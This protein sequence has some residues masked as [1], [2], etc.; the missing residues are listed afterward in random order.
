MA[1]IHAASFD[2]SWDALEMSA[3][4]Q[5]DVCLGTG[6][7]LSAFIICSQVGDQ[8]E[9][10]TLATH[11][12][13]RQNGLGYDLLDHAIQTLRHT[14]VADL[15][16]EV[17]EDNVAAKALYRKMG[18]TPIGRRPGYYRRAKGRVA[19]ITFSKKL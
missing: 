19:A 3:H 16:L 6:D 17:A 12:D 11:P 14:G 4:C 8:S 15:F 5:K 7:P 1:D 10:L 18:F 2:K 9:I 13:A